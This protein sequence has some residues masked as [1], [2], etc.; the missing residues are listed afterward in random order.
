MLVNTTS[1]LLERII[2]DLRA[3]DEEID[4]DASVDVLKLLLDPKA[5]EARRGWI[6][7]ENI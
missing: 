6:M 7:E 2:N 3:L 5:N 4:N 1:R